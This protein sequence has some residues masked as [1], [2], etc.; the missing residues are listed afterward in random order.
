MTGKFQDDVLSYIAREMYPFDSVLICAPKKVTVP[1]GSV[2]SEYS[3]PYVEI[4]GGDR[5]HSRKSSIY[6]L[7]VAYFRAV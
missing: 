1:S 3:R 7:V 4:G 5:S 2:V 6:R